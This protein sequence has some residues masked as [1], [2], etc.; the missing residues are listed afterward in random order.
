MQI[1][2]DE[3]KNSDEWMSARKLALEAQYKK[4]SGAA[5]NLYKFQDALLRTWGVETGLIDPK[6][7]AE[8]KKK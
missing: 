6:A 4:F 3:R 2:A 1:F 5:E 7:V 8:W